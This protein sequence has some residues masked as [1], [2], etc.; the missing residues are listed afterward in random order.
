MKQMRMIGMAILL[1]FAT[2]AGWKPLKTLGHY[3][4]KAF[5]LKKGAAYVEIRKHSKHTEGYSPKVVKRT[6]VALRIYHARP[7]NKSV[8]AQLPLKKRYGFKKG[9][10]SG[11]VSSGS[12]YYNGFMQDSTG[13]TWRLES[14]K[15]VIDMIRPIDTSADIELV[16]W[17]HSDAETEAS[18][19]SAKYKK[20]G[21]GY[22]IRQHY[23][24]NESSYGC[25]DFTYQ[26]K[27]SRS[28]R[29]TQKKLLK[30]RAAKECGGE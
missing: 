27:M 4:P 17:L 6:S 15:E 1:S 20:S 24:I 28:G 9:K 18:T 7:R 12:W 13:K 5:S 26:Y 16:L 25:G 29:I 11:M 30:K 19:Y 3:G 8:F 21:K 10:Y 14:A 2:Q 23:I 22:L